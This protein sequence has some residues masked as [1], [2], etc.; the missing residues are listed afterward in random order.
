MKNFNLLLLF[1]LVVLSSCDSSKIYEKHIDKVNW[2]N[3]CDNTSEFYLKNRYKT[4]IFIIL[5][6][7]TKNNESN[8]NILPKEI[9]MY[10]IG[11]IC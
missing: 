2:D 11:F 8:L 5:M 4:Q 6:S 1:S 3:I 7:R 9:I 10:I